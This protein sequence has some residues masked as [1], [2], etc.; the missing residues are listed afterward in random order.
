MREKVTF[1]KKSHFFRKEEKFGFII[2]IH[3]FRRWWKIPRKEGCQEPSC[4][5]LK[6]LRKE[7]EYELLCFKIT[8]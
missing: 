5:I 1:K 6:W 8:K 7:D 2:Y 3:D 4:R